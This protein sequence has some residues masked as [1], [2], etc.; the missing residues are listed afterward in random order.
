M[1]RVEF[2]SAAQ[3][4]KESKTLRAEGP[5]TAI[6][7][8]LTPETT[9]LEG[10]RQY[11]AELKAKGYER[12][13]EGSGDE[14]DDGYNRFVTR[15]YPKVKG[16]ERLYY[17]HDFNHDDKRYALYKLTGA[18]GAVDVSLYAFAIKSACGVRGAKSRYEG[19][20]LER[21]AT[22]WRLMLGYHWR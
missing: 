6:Y 18:D 20:L 4:L 3:A 17:V 11:E 2:D 14:L 19:L 9:T 21:S 13:F 1:E 8:K 10:I 12:L 15:I 16:N 7:D 5:R 22:P